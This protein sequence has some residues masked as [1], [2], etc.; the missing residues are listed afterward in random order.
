[1]APSDCPPD[2][3]RPASDLL[4]R[5]RKLRRLGTL[6]EHLPVPVRVEAGKQTI[7]FVVEHGR[8]RR[9]DG[10]NFAIEGVCLVIAPLYIPAGR[11]EALRVT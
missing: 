3:M 1:M 6:D 10:D 5:L 9:F 8:A 2:D 11:M 4:V 7:Q